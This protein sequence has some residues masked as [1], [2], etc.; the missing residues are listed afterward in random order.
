MAQACTKPEELE[1]LFQ[2]LD[3]WTVY[4]P[5]PEE[6]KVYDKEVSG[7]LIKAKA[8]VKTI[9]PGTSSADGFERLMKELADLLASSTLTIADKK[10]QLK[11]FRLEKG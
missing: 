7:F 11:V 6:L 10:P 8:D 2:Q 3:H 4:R 9:P 5:E 1:D